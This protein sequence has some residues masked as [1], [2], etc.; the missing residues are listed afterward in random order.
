LTVVPAGLAAL[1]FQPERIIAGHAVL[2]RITLEGLAPPGGAVIS[3][4]SDQAALAVVPATVLVPAGRSSITFPVATHPTRVS[5]RA[6]LSASYAGGSLSSRL[7][8]IRR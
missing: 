1:T 8:V 2:G 7:T 6:V 5:T 4:S 3:L